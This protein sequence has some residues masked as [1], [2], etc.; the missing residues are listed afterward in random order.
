VREQPTRHAIHMQKGLVGLWFWCISYVYL[1][2]KQSSNDSC[3]FGILQQ[4]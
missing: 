1:F 2:I 3:L 4:P